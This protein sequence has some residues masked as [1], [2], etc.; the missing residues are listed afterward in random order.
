MAG[1]RGTKNKGINGLIVNYLDIGRR[2][3][4]SFRKGRD[5]GMLFLKLQRKVP[6]PSNKSEGDEVKEVI[7]LVL[8]RVKIMTML[9]TMEKVQGA[10]KKL[11]SQPNSAKQGISVSNPI[12]I[13]IEETKRK[14]R[15]YSPAALQFIGPGDH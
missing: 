10:I 13:Q 8:H 14:I 7:Q 6:A 1:K 9:K 4:A 11:A 2:S 3:P 12:R 15:V 5:Q